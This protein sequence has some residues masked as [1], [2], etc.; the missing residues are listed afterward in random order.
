MHCIKYIAFTCYPPRPDSSQD[1]GLVGLHE[2]QKQ[3]EL[4]IM[5]VDCHILMCSKLLQY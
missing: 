2:S 3:C 5:L 1:G 4:F